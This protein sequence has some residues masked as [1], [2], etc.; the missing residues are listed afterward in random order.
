MAQYFTYWNTISQYISNSALLKETWFTCNQIAAGKTLFTA[1]S[2]KHA[3][4]SIRFV[5]ACPFHVKDIFARDCMGLLFFH[6]HQR[7]NFKHN[8]QQ[9]PNFQ[10]RNFVSDLPSP[11][12]LRH[13]SKC[14]PHPKQIPP[15]IV[16]WPAAYFEN[17]Y[18]SSCLQSGYSVL[19]TNPAY[20]VLNAARRKT[21][22]W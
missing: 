18:A 3:G 21:L 6:W 9:V 5:P 11:A 17:G 10:N 12:Q 14:L 13:V 2:N 7:N 16:T 15:H 4:G 19:L 20:I 8:C 22:H 1:A